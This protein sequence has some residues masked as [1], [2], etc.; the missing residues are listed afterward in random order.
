MNAICHPIKSLAALAGLFVCAAAIGQT[1]PAQPAQ[2]APAAPAPA[3]KPD[4]KA[5]KPEAK[6]ETPVLSGT[7]KSI[8][9]KDID[10]SSYAGQVVLV[11]NVASR[12]GFTRQYAGLESLYKSKKD[13]GLVILGFPA[14]DF[15]SQEPG[16]DAEI[17]SFCSANFGVTFPMFSKVSVK[18]ASQHP[19]FARLSAAKGEPRW[20]F[21]KYLVGRDGAIIERFDSRIAPDDPAMLKAIDAALGAVAPAA[22]NP[23]APGSAP[24]TPAAP[25]GKP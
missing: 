24:A 20:N 21:T 8:D 12:C 19:L 2:P 6:Q 16:T 13:A 15:G 5:S 1:Q 18:G 22:T 4:A 3:A 7:V 25:S 9:G 14:N 11:V 23:A 17:A 10:L